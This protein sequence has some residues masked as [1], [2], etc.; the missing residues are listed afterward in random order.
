MSEPSFSHDGLSF[1]LSYEFSKSVPP[2]SFKYS[3]FEGVDCKSDRLIPMEND[4]ISS[5]Y[6]FTK[7]DSED[8]TVVH[9]SCSMDP[10]TLTRSPIYSS[11]DSGSARIDMCI[12]ASLFTG[13][14]SDQQSIEVNFLETPVLYRVAVQDGVSILFDVENDPASL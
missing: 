14:A 9:V 3:L 11:R 4:Y 12:R 7:R 8:I 10:K 1:V 2:E 5:D 13:D 6:S